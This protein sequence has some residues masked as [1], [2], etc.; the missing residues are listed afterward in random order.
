MQDAGIF[1]PD[2]NIS[3]VDERGED[4]IE[5][6][7]RLMSTTQRPTAIFTTNMELSL[8][9]MTA[10]RQLGLRVP[11]DI[12]IVGFDDPAWAPL[13]DPPLTTVATPAF[14]IGKLAALRLVRATRRQSGAGLRN[15]QL[16]PSLIE[17]ASVL[18]LPGSPAGW[19]SNRRQGA[20]A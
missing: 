8:H 11:E 6:A 14:R 10:F 15:S 19:P 4:G 1:V 17:R 3:L 13:V 5:G 16:A 2:I 18:R 20:P 12:S 9:A 7:S